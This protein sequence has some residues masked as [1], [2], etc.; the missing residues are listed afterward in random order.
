MFTDSWADDGGAGGT[1]NVLELVSGAGG[2]A[3]SVEVGPT[4]AG[5]GSLDDS[6]TIVL[7]VILTEKVRVGSRELVDRGLSVAIPDEGSGVVLGRLSAT[8]VE[9]ISGLVPE[10]VSE[11]VL[12]LEGVVSRWRYASPQ[13]WC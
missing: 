8:M 13:K 5:G 7:D 9:G 2:G 11:A 3:V 6:S 1:E 4:E 10:T 12:T